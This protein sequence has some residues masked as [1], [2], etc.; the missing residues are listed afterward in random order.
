MAFGLP[1]YKL[2]EA[3]NVFWCILEALA[4]GAWFY[5]SY[6]SSYYIKFRQLYCRT[7]FGAFHGVV[8]WRGDL[9]TKYHTVRIYQVM[10]NPARIQSECSPANKEG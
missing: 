4:G 8:V 2:C 3:E 1:G 9:L 6:C 10:A 7:S 5:G